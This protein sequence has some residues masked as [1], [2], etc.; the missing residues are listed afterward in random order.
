MRIANRLAL[1]LAVVF[2]CSCSVNEDLEEREAL[3]LNFFSHQSEANF[4]I[5]NPSFDAV[6]DLNDSENLQQYKHEPYELSDGFYGLMLV[7]F[8]NDRLMQV[9]F[10]P[11]NCE[12]YEAYFSLL[13][14]ADDAV[15]FV[16]NIDNDGACY[17]S[18]SDRSLQKEFDYF[19]R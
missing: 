3:I 18:W 10:Y 5:Q 8:F 9:I 13:D 17:G 4:V 11:V 6:T 19:I 15:E 14:R 12:G 7:T 2:S 1:L 16:Y